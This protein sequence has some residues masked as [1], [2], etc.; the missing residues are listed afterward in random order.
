MTMTQCK[1]QIAILM[2]TYNGEAFLS[3]QLDSLLGQTFADWHL[4]IH[5]D[6]SADGTAGLLSQYAR[7]YPQQI[8]LLNYPPQ[9]GACRNFMS[10][11]DAVEAPY[12][13]FCDQ[14]DVWLPMKVEKT[15]ERMKL[16][17]RQQPSA[18]PV[19]V[20]TDLQ[21]ADARLNITAPS[22]I[23]SQQIKLERITTFEDYAATNTVTG[24][25]M[26]LNHQAK[27]CIRRPFD[28]AIMHDAWICLSVVAAGGIVN[29][30]DEPLVSYRQHVSNTLGA[31]DMSR[32]T[33]LHKLR[34]LRQMAKADTA[35]YREMN[36]V[37]PLSPW[38]FIKAKWRYRR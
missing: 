24:C 38:A 3:E 2:A 21:V 36:A 29:F 7:Q 14:D 33:T 16:L 25:A 20:H 4:Y 28:K 18:G 10:L 17:E 22:F 8:T 23:R 15:L 34:N 19:I 6:G 1:Q 9:G 26:M 35:H 30:I 11:L 5:D 12:Y 13:M 31:R 32:Q 27:L 37:R